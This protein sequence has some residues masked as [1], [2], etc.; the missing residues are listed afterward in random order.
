MRT[1]TAS[2][3]CSQRISPLRTNTFE[4]LGTPHRDEW[5]AKPIHRINL[6]SPLLPYRWLE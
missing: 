2:E 3:V 4:P 5:S 1:F 6:G